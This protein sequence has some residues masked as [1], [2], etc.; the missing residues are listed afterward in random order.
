MITKF[1][2]YSPKDK[3]KNY[4]EPRSKTR[5]FVNADFAILITS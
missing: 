3:V 1:L 4:A 5:F 2:C